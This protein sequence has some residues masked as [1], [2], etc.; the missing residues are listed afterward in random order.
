MPYISNYVKCFGQTFNHTDKSLNMS[1][2]ILR[3]EKICELIRE[4]INNCFLWT[5]LPMYIFFD[6]VGNY[7][8][9]HIFVL[10]VLS[11]KL[12]VFVYQSKTDVLNVI[13]FHSAKEKDAN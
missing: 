9:V 3:V 11:T 5:Q 10:G 2:C 8:L 6:V 4:K 1:F 12:S 7:V 13:G